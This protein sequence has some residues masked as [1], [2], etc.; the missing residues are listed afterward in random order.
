MNRNKKL[1][2]KLLFTTIGLSSLFS[3]AANCFNLDVLAKDV[4]ISKSNKSQQQNAGPLITYESEQIGDREKLKVTV[5]VEDRSG[6]GIKEFRDH[7]G[8]LINGNSYTFEISRRGDY[9]FTAIDNNNQESSV[10]IDDFWVNPYTSNRQEV[11]IYRNTHGSTYWASSNI[12]DWL[13]SKESIVSY[14]SNAPTSENTNGSGYDKEAGFL[15]EFTEEEYNAI[16]VV[17]RI[18]WCNA[19]FD[20]KANV[21]KYTNNP[22]HFNEVMP[23]TLSNNLSQ[24]LEYKN[25]SYSIERDKV[26][27][28][29]AFEIYWYLERRGF[30]LKKQPTERV[31]YKYNINSNYY[32]WFLNG[33]TSGG[34][35]MNNYPSELGYNINNLGRYHYSYTSEN[36]LVPMLNIKSNFVMKNGKRA[37]D[38][39]I[40]DLVEFGAYRGENILWRVVNISNNNSPL[41]ISEHVIDIKKFDAK[42]DNSRLYSD[43]IAYDYADINFVD[44]LQYKPINSNYSYDIEIPSGIVKNEDELKV[45]QN[46]SFDLELEFIDDESGIDCVKMPD[47]NITYHSSFV[48]TF[49]KNG[50]YVFEVMDRAGNF[51]KFGI[52][53]GNI[54]DKVSL[55][56]QSEAENKWSNNGNVYIESTNSVRRF[57]KAD[58]G[59]T[60]KQ[61]EPLP[62]YISYSGVTFK[63]KG[64][65][66]VLSVN[67]E[68]LNDTSKNVNMGFVYDTQYGNNQYTYTS[69]IHYNYGMSRVVI[70]CKEGYSVDVDCDIK[71]PANYL[72][73]LRPSVETGRGVTVRFD[74]E[75]YLQDDSDFA[76]QSIE[77]PDG[78]IINDIKEYMDIVEEGIHNLRYKV[79]D[80]RGVTTEKTI[81]VKIDKTAPELNLIYNKDEL[82]NNKSATINITASDSLSG[83]KRIRLPNGNYVNSN[84]AVYNIN[85]NGGY[86]FE[87]EDV[88]G[89]ITSK[90]VSI[91]GN[92]S[93]LN[94]EVNKSDNWT[95]RGVQIN[96]DLRK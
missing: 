92:N 55:K 74:I 23:I 67:K 80:N 37:G 96:I 12:R 66:E 48:Y 47:G 19:Y 43:Y 39:N 82:V 95:N 13:N 2:A 90:A 18:V 81:T 72:R 87:C 1:T 29:N 58:V 89:N 30:E 86:V 57:I 10:K 75:Y 69:G 40:G 77:L 36:G 5:K 63:V 88:A 17:D 3:I 21:S 25:Y 28:P 79:L 78:T 73:N 64:K 52:P 41:L 16:A 38:L 31:K 8:K 51:N 84:K 22:G 83:V 42:G 7:T 33:A 6:L 27:I 60:N 34:V 35:D 53:I 70:E 20:T 45:R 91:N 24:V 15:N 62:N 44:S 46:L 65:I 68:I 61:T 11:S 26:Y 56:I 32:S 9:T 59:S 50:N 76:I 54:N 85:G 71:I 93:N 4:Q 14:T 94:T 49:N